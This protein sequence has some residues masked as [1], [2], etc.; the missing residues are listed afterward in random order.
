MTFSSSKRVG[1]AGPHAEYMGYRTL[2]F[3]IGTPCSTVCC[4]PAPSG[5]TIYGVSK[6]VRATV[7]I[8]G[9]LQNSY[10]NEVRVLTQPTGFFCAPYTLR[11]K[12]YALRLLVS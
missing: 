7:D 12:I 9:R 8:L 4:Y 1:A 10:T 2:Y 3:T 6:A 5:A 11:S